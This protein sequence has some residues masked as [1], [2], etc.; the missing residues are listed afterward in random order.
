MIRL[1]YFC[2]ADDILLVATSQHGASH[3]FDDQ[4]AR[5]CKSTCLCQA[6][7][8]LQTACLILAPC[9]ILQVTPDNCANRV[10]QLDI[11]LFTE[12]ICT[13]LTFVAEA[14]CDK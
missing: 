6:I 12:L 9:A 14:V 4:V 13:R 2:L 1:L 7:C 10:F 11:G 5:C 3:T 8:A